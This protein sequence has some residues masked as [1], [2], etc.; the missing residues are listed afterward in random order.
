MSREP[1]QPGTTRDSQRGKQMDSLSSE[2]PSPPLF[3]YTWCPGLVPSLPLAAERHAESMAGKERKREKERNVA[4]SCSTTA[5][6]GP[7]WGP[8]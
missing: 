5:P 7:Q 4:F 3:V 6:R 1:Q 2:M 8:L